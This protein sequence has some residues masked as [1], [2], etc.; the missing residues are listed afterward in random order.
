VGP[1]GLGAGRAARGRLFGAMDTIP[2]RH[3]RREAAA[4]RAPAPP[5]CRLAAAQPL[6]PGAKGMA[7]GV[8][9]APEGR[10]VGGHVMALGLARNRLLIVAAAAPPPPARPPPHGPACRRRHLNLGLRRRMGAARPRA[11]ARLPPSHLNLGSRTRPHV[12]P[13]ASRPLP[14]AP[15]SQPGIA[16]PHGPLRRGLPSC[17]LSASTQTGPHAGAGRPD[18]VKCQRPDRPQALGPRAAAALCGGDL[19]HVACPRSWPATRGNA[20]WF[21]RAARPGR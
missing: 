2:V 9:A 6:C 15:P 1:A 12:L 19:G 16:P 7:A 20:P 5:P 18:G 21:Q 10:H 14:R 8:A 17:A 13:C 4:S 3:A 11:A